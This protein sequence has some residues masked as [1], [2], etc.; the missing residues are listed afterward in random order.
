MND[1]SSIYD[2]KD[3]IL[4]DITPKY[5]AIDDISLLNAGLYGMMTDVASTVAE[6]TMRV[7]TRY[8]SE[9]IPGHAVLPDFIYAHAAN[10]GI[11]DIFATCSNCKAVIFI[12]EQEVLNNGVQDGRYTEYTIDSD[13]VVYIDEVP[14][15]LPY[16]IKI[17]SNYYNGKFNHRCYWNA[18]INNSIVKEELPYVTCAKTTIHGGKDYYIALNVTLYQYI[19]KRTTEQII[20]NT[21]LNIP[22]V[23]VTYEQSL[24]NF[25]VIYTDSNGN[26]IQLEKVLS[27]GAPLTRP[28]VYYTVEGDNTIRLSFS[29]DDRYFIPEYGSEL[30]ILMYECM[31]DKGNFPL[32]TEDNIFVVGKSE[33]TA[34]SYNNEVPLQANMLSDAKYG[35]NAYTLDE[36]NQLTTERQIT[37]DSITTDND[38]N[39]YLNTQAS[40]YQTMTKSIKIRDDFANRIYCCYTRL[41][42]DENIYPTNN[43]NLKINL[44]D[45]PVPYD[46]SQDKLIIPCGTRLGYIDDSTEWCR[47]LKPEEEKQEVEYTTMGLIVVDKEETTVASYMNSIDNRIIL[48]YK[49]INDDSLFQFIAKRLYINRAAALGDD[50]YTFTL[51]IQSTDLTVNKTSNAIIEEYAGEEDIEI[52]DE[53]EVELIVEKLRVYLFIE[54][55]EG[56]Y[57]EMTR[58]P[59]DQGM[60][61]DSITFSCR[62]TTDDTLNKTNIKLSGLTFCE[63]QQVQDCYTS[64][65]NPPLRFLVFYDEEVV[66]G[67][68]YEELIPD[69]KGYTLCNVFTPND[70]NLYFAYPLK[71]IRP[72]LE[73]VESGIEGFPFAIHILDMPVVGRDF[74]LTEG[75]L[76]AFLE[77]VNRQHSFLSGLKITSNFAIYMRFFNTYGRSRIFTVT[78]GELLNRV[79][80]SVTVSIKFFDGVVV[81]DYIPEIKRTIK[82]YVES[83]NYLENSTGINT[84]KLSVLSKTLHD[85]Y[86]EQIDYIVMGSINGYDSNIQTIIMDKDLSAKENMYLIPEFL[87]IDVKDIEVTIL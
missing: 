18:K 86:K 39:V 44:D 47:V 81:E 79:N 63:S 30:E 46:P 40:L 45:L 55:N 19:R 37:I 61:Q 83:V 73:F 26:K 36:I 64:M 28:F 66:R 43:L 84:I 52:E 2:I 51:T 13:L 76:S 38:L 32:Y 31:G 77:R 14:F 71:L 10:Y 24:C 65:Q 35:K 9:Q 59:D 3:F 72:T 7:A 5:Y 12:K 54:T 21:T 70:T 42:D 1:Y 6:D 85:S 16:D 8:I 15:S 58:L 27:N 11:N 62:I 67:H 4:N 53:D 78:N 74:L 60:D 68:D 22:Y 80:C 57:I 82:E 69:T 87:T 41:R 75:N 33:D 34:I 29:N 17:R 25:E 20:T 56:H 48:D 23:D 50:G 49:Y